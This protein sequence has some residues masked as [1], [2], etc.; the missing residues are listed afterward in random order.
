MTRGTP[1]PI[2]A[3]IKFG[4]S[5]SG[6]FRG[7]INDTLVISSTSVTTKPPGTFDSVSDFALPGDYYNGAPRDTNYFCDVSNI[8]LATAASPPPWTDAG[9]NAFIPSTVNALDYA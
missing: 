8:L 9:G 6:I 1:V 3:Y 5:N 7:W 2:C 4:T